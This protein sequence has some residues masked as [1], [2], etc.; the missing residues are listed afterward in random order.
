MKINTLQKSERLCSKI[1]IDKL[2][3]GGARSMTAF[4]IRVV[5]LKVEKS[6]DSPSCELLIS[7]PKHCFKRA[8]KRNRVKRQV[9]EAY[10]R[11]KDLL[12]DKMKGTPNEKLIMAFIWLDNNLHNSEQVDMKITSLIQRISEK[13]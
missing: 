1:L 5:F 6:N 8:V 7:V 11:Q 3:A 2:F 10:R 13:V 4:P 12:I 9:R